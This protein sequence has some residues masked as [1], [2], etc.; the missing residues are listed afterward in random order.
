MSRIS[1]YLI[2]EATI[3]IVHSLNTS[4]LDNCNSIHYGLPTTLLNKLQL[5]LNSTACLMLGIKLFEHIT[6]SPRKLDWLPIEQCIML[7]ILCLTLKAFSGLD[8]GYI[9][10]LITPYSPPRVIRSPTQHLLCI[11]KVSTKRLSEC[12]FSFTTLTL[13]NN[14][15]F[16]LR[17]S[18]SLETFK[19]NSRLNCSNLL[20]I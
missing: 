9:A 1:K 4:K 17:Q 15:P 6:P 20:M 2:P 7:K 18:P 5:S 16:K 14:R 12:T 19:S 11:S 10:D 8:P 13:Y 3:T